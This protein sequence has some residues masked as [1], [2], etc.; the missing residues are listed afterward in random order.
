M[1]KHSNFVGFFIGDEEK[2]FYSIDIRAYVKNL[3]RL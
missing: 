1:D 2:K 3:L